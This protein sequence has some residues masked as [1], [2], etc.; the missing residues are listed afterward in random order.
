MSGNVSYYSAYNDPDEPANA[1]V[2]CDVHHFTFLELRFT[3]T[4]QT[5]RDCPE[6]EKEAFM[7]N[8]RFAKSKDR[9]TSWIG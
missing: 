3:D 8:A 7:R 4:F 6:C 2:F 1:A 5:Y 9:G